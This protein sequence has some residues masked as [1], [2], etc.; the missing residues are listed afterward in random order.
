MEI[1]SEK[2]RKFLL[3]EK[4]KHRDLNIMNIRKY[5]VL[6]DL[7]YLKRIEELYKEI[8]GD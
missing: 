7:I 2:L 3:E 6:S 1:D 4:E 8:F 5:S